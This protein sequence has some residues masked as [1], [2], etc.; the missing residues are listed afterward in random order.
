MRPAKRSC[1][2]LP[3]SRELNLST[4]Y[5]GRLRSNVSKKGKRRMIP[6][7]V[8]QSETNASAQEALCLLERLTEMPPETH[9]PLFVHLAILLA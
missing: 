2:L 3:Q 9:S 7:P 6:A 1:R 5:G 8:S 4:E